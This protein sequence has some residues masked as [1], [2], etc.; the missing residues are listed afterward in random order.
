ML[1]T[2]AVLTAGTNPGAPEFTEDEIQAG[3]E[4]PETPASMSRH[5]PMAP[6]A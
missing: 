1:V 5:M 2:G 3:V 4:T 6:K